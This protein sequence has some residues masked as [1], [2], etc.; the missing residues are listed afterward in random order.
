[1]NIV[2][3]GVIAAGVSGTVG[4]VWVRHLVKRHGAVTLVGR[5]FSGAHL[6][7]L[8]ITDAGWFARGTRPLTADRRASQWAHMPRAHRMGIRWA[9]VVI[10]TAGIWLYIDHP[11]VAL[12]IIG[13][14]TLGAAGMAVRWVTHQLRN[15]TDTVDTLRPLYEAIAP[16]TGHPVAEPAS[17]WISVKGVFDT[18]NQVDSTGVL[19]I[20]FP[21]KFVG[22]AGSKTIVLRAAET[23]VDV[24]LQGSWRLKGRKP[25]AEFTRAPEPPKTALL[26][27]LRDRVDDLSSCRIYMA[28]GM[29][30][31]HQVHDFDRDAPHV[32]FSG[33]TGA[34]KST[35]LGLSVAQF[36]RKGAE[37]II[38]CDPKRGDS[39]P[40]L[41]GI[42]GISIYDEIA[43]MWW[44]IHW[45]R[46]EMERR[47]QEYT[48]ED[49]KKIPPLLLVIDELNMFCDQSQEFWDQYA[50][51]G[52]RKTPPIFK[53]IR[54]IA[55]QGRSRRCFLEVAA[56][57]FEGQLLGNAVRDQFGGKAMVRFSAKAWT[58]ITGLGAKP[59]VSR[60]PG[61]GV[62]VID[63]DVSSA[64]YLY[65]SA[66][67]IRSYAQERALPVTNTGP[68]DVLV[69]D[70]LAVFGASDGPVDAL[71]ADTSDTEPG[72]LHLVGPPAL[73]S[74]R[75]AA[76]DTGEGLLPLKLEALR[77]RRSRGINDFPEGR[78][79][80]GTL[81]FAPAE[82]LDWWAAQEGDVEAAG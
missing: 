43:Q 51:K 82:L 20:Q 47:F 5:Y 54:A 79:H 72:R 22:D 12:S 33:G 30:G 64:Q 27:D 77:R 6:H 9:A 18:P 56:Q 4:A 19:R 34:G 23:K 40:F 35:F 46:M 38:I 59:R 78:N 32:A 52:A 1:M 8:Q 80:D 81:F 48:R 2:E 14:A 50:P 3:V 58:S 74:L 57:N 60:L 65:A 21:A 37:H 63:D 73:Y 25:Y 42:E 53:D 39:L 13:A 68:G 15:R 29:N 55:F 10:P 75:Q 76:S 17:K 70:V 45:A 24:D 16:V 36:H 44:A 67:E 69:S 71:G 11:I 49:L 61:R 66:P 7:G 28:A 31:T 62:W 41:D 26:K